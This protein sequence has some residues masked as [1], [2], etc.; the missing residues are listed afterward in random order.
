MST[1]AP[2]PTNVLPDEDLLAIEALLGGRPDAAR[3]VGNG[4]NGRVYRVRR[5]ADEFA[6]KLYFGPTADGRSRVDV[7]F[8][9]LKFLRTLGLTCVPEPLKADPARR[10]AL[11]SFAG[12]EPVEA[13][14]VTAR[15]VSE[16]LAFVRELRRCAAA[17]EAT[18][19]PT[20]AEAFFTASGL[21]GNVRARLSVLQTQNGSGPVYEDFRRFLA[22]SFVPAL[23]DFAAKAEAAGLGELDGS[24]R[25]LSPSDFGF[26]NVLRAPDGRLTFVDFE[27]FGWD[28]PAKTWSDARL[29]PRMR[30]A[31]ERRRELL[32]GLAEI[33]S[34]DSR[35]ARRVEALYPLFALK[36][37]MILLNEFRPDQI[38]RRRYVDRDPQKI[39]AIQR[40]QLDAAR[41][42]L[43]ETLREP[44]RPGSPAVPPARAVPS[45]PIALDARSKDLRRR[46]IQ[47]LERAGRGH[48][49][50]AFSCIE[51]LRVLFDEVLHYK[52]TEPRWP[53]RDRF[54]LSKGHSCLALY[55]LLQEK[56]FFP[57]EE[58]W[59]FCK[60]DGRLGGHPEP[61]TPGVEVSTG[62]LG[63]GLPVAVGL[64]VA[65]KRR[66]NTHRVFTVL[67]DG[68][69]HEGSVWEAALTAAKH[70]LDNL[71]VIVD[72]NK[73][74]T[75]STMDRLLPLEPFKDK[76]EAFG[77]ATRE[78]DGH[79]VAA[80]RGVFSAIPFTPGRPT[81]ILCH[82]VKGKGIPFAE[83]NPGWHH[84]SSLK[85]ADI[86]KLRSGLEA[87][88]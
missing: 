25:I 86:E 19:Q 40:Q 48:V 87:S 24:R 30:L 69:C 16:L 63:H 85:P 35:W 55:V 29:H 66:G 51:I 81:A 37:C 21:I 23:E 27:Y 59:K 62:S 10:A 22:Q 80:L 88:P 47:V 8:S 44:V 43:A 58:L 42:L 4:R 46:M 6:A 38:E 50:G 71:I 64:A 17:P 41:A 70:R 61:K 20:A 1:P 18:S 83:G 33:F 56:G 78:V 77:F 15:D 7:E 75:Y 13:S 28:D 34:S 11:Y 31:P 57:E 68:E 73:M 60:F 67:G 3:R 76:W 74:A 39:D 53:G 45:A 9:A 32:D 2:S 36:W 65:A 5:G 84:K 26:H 72:Y 54:I 12:G 82:T 49:G 14:A 79:D 52:P